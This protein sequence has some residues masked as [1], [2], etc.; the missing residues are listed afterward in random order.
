MNTLYIAH[1]NDVYDIEEQHNEPI[2]GVARFIPKLRELQQQYQGQ[3]LTIFSGDV[4]SPSTL[5]NIYKGQQLI[6]PLN[7]MNID[8]A[9]P[10]N[11]DFDFPLV[12]VNN[13][14]SQCNFPF[15]LSNIHDAKTQQTLAKTQPYLIKQFNGMKIGFFALGEEEWFL[16]I[17]T[18]P[19][20][21][22]DYED[23]IHCAERMV[24]ILN[25]EKCDL[26]I[27]LTHMRIP[28]D[29]KLLEEVKGIDLVL[30]GHDHLVAFEKID[31]S[32][33]V[34]SGSNF[35]NITLVKY[36]KNGQVDAQLIEINSQIKP[37]PEIEKYVDVQLNEYKQLSQRVILYTK[38]DLDGRFQNV[39]SRET[40]MANFFADLLRLTLKTEIGFFNSGSLRIDSKIDEGPVTYYH[41]DKIFSLPDLVVTFNISGKDLL[42]TLENS[43]QKWPTFDGR[44]LD[45]SGMQITFDPK[46][47][48]KIQ[49]VLIN[50]EPLVLDRQYF[51]GSLLYINLGVDGFFKI[52]EQNF[53]L[54]KSSGILVLQYMHKQLESEEF[55]QLYKSQQIEMNGVKYWEI[56]P[57]I[58]GRYQLF[59]QSFLNL[60]DNLIIQQFNN[61]I[62]VRGIRNYQ[63]I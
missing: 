47:N 11:H 30:G 56:N 22:M 25:Q 3:I 45:I 23:Y 57:Q 35:R 58:N 33:I 26:I 59:Q 36:N 63:I 16:Q 17:E 37:D 2:G 31:Q 52:P 24:E 19:L 32:Y 54:K 48:P 5:S 27:C 13:L 29:R 20:D 55:H 12:Q 10:G 46:K 8:I 61:S 34:K 9:C 40:N 62:N 18:I 39:R 44:F 51:T 41:I 21:E 50:E 4:F 42:F 15:I 38:V 49:Q 14:I 28:S 53:V 6:Y 1:F 60:Q 43:I 7:Q